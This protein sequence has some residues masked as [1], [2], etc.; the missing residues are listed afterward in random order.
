MRLILTDAGLPEP[1]L[2]W[3]VHGDRGEFLGFVDQAYPELKIAIE[4]EGEQHRIDPGQ[5]L[6]DIARYER[7]AEA[8]W[9]VIRVTKHDVFTAAAPLVAR[10]RR[11]I[12]QATR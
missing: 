7:L 3:P 10:V 12:A 6:R 1:L 5:W 8:G 2:N 9:R 4:Y 11:T